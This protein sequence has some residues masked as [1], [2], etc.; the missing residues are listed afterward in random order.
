MFDFGN[1]LI[2]WDPRYVYHDYFQNDEAGMERFLTEVSFHDYTRQF[3][4]GR[5]NQEV[6]DE[7]S[8]KHPQYARLLEIYDEYWI[9]SVGGVIEATADL[10]HQ[11]KQVGYPI[12]GLSNWPSDKFELFRPRQEIFDWFDEI[13]ISGQV[14]L[15]KPDRRIYDVHYGQSTPPVTPAIFS[16]NSAAVSSSG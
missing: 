13:V 16:F 11:L 10:I 14:K 12:Y 8:S 7:F 3:D 2:D 1:V 15:A 9:K 6:I 5:P 4:L